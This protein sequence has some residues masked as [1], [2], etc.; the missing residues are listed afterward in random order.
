ML[1]NIQAASL[2]AAAM[3]QFAPSLYFKLHLSV[4]E[5]QVV[6]GVCSLLEAVGSSDP[7]GGL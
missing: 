7:R 6:S 1:Q 3:V 2:C 4:Q 5:L